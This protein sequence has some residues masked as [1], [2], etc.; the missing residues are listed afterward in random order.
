ML[1]KD[2][3]QWAKLS[4]VRSKLPNVKRYVLME[5]KVDAAEGVMGWEEFLSAGINATP[6]V[7]QE[8]KD[9]LA[10]NQPSEM[11]MLIYTSGTT[12]DPKGVMISHDNLWSL[13]HS[14]RQLPTYILHTRTHYFKRGREELCV[15][16]GSCPKQRMIGSISR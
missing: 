1:V 10:A 13:T 14:I 2:L 3:D 12:G 9:R 4:S 6:Q 11:C 8:F 16:T 15:P 7:E 5:G